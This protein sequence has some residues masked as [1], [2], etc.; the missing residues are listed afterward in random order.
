M[1]MTELICPAC[2]SRGRRV[3]PVTIENLAT[4]AVLATLE[5]TAGFAYCPATACDVVWFHP[6]GNIILGRADCRVPVGL[7][8]ATPPR[9]IC[10]C[11]E[12]TIEEIE[13]EIRDRGATDIPATIAAKCRQGLDRCEETNPQG[14]CCLGNI[15]KVVKAAPTQH[16][17]SQRNR[18]NYSLR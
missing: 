12:H 11:F 17:H 2:G 16:T 5:D 6:S 1:A 8:E 7:K 3:P 14:S 15:N 10:Y 4:P 18:Y 13:S 9:P